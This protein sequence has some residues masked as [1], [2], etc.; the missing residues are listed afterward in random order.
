MASYAFSLSAGSQ[1]GPMIAGY[2]VQARGWR[3]HF[4]LCIIIIAFNLVMTIFLLPE[5]LYETEHVEGLTAFDIDKSTQA[6]KIED[7]HIEDGGNTTSE[8]QQEPIC[9]KTY[10]RGL[11]TVTVSDEAR[12]SGVLRHWLYLF[13]LPLPL[14]LVPSVLLASVSYGVVLGGYVTDSF[15]FTKSCTITGTL[16]TPLS[17]SLQSQR[18][19]QHSSAP[20]LTTSP[21]WIWDCS[22]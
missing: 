11:V 2:L 6:E 22:P 12:K 1:F 20:L 10:L 4:I 18:Y 5:T 15:I 21:Q 13:W 3:W 8:Q 14:L 7:I 9:W 19:P 17:E 16:L